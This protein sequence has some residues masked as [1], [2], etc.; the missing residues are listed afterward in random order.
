MSMP[1]GLGMPGDNKAR[2]AHGQL[3][4]LL[5]ARDDPFA[6]H[7]LEAAA[8][9]ASGD[10]PMHSGGHEQSMNAQSQQASGVLD[11]NRGMHAHP[12]YVS[13]QR[14]H[15]RSGSGVPALDPE[16][17][18]MKTV[19]HP[20]SCMPVSAASRQSGTDRQSAAQPWGMY[21]HHAP[22]NQDMYVHSDGGLHMAH[23]DMTA[24]DARG[25]GTEQRRSHMPHATQPPP[26]QLWKTAL[27]KQIE[28]Q[29]N[30]QEQLDV[31]ALLL[32]LNELL[33]C[34]MI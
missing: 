12:E 27:Q 17:V 14:A 32:L 33:C 19:L 7:P 18:Q 25:R 9:G 34:D 24:H 23:A 5:H 22:A 11:D 28:L 8:S 2:Q 1:V 3:H 29:R 21:P 4:S 26:E 6:E 16:Q 10:L 30:L 15:S 20:S 13:T 31:R